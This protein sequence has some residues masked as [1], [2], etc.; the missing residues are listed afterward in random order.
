MKIKDNM[1]GPDGK[2]KRFSMLHSLQQ[3]KDLC[4]KLA[5]ECAGVQKENTQE[6]YSLRRG[7]IPRHLVITGPAMP[8]PPT[9]PPKDLS[10]KAREKIEEKRFIMPNKMAYLRYCPGEFSHF[11][12]YR[13]AFFCSE[14]EKCPHKYAFEVHFKVSNCGNYQYFSPLNLH[15]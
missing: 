8:R 3:A 12:P 10:D 7:G 6:N 11:K 14:G 13:P 5:P 9:V 2:K 4:D 1:V 15:A